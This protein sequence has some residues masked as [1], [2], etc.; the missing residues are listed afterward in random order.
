MVIP[1]ETVV[2][3]GNEGITTVDDLMDFDKDT[4]QQVAESLRRPGGRIPDPTPNS[5]PGAKIPTPPL[6]FG[7]KSQKQLLA[8]CDIV[9]YYETT[10][11]GITTD[12]I[13]WNTVINNFETQWKVIK[14]RKKGDKP[15]APKSTK[16]LPEIKW[17]HTFGEYLNRI[18]GHRT[19]PLS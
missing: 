3:L 13:S 5:A 1:D 15:D 16:A 12:N 9:R 7:A 4:I 6:V 14:E 10:G 11:R 19:I 18:I 8:A 2:Q 17:T